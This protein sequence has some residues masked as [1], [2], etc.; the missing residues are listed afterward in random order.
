MLS[1][2]DVPAIR[3]ISRCFAIESAAIR[4]TVAGGKS[5]DVTVIIV[6]SRPVSGSARSFIAVTP[7]V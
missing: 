3:D 5:R 1:V 2:N 7:N 4:Y 6:T